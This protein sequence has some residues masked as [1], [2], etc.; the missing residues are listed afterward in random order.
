MI[1]SVLIVS[2]IPLTIVYF[3]LADLWPPSWLDITDTV[4]GVSIIA[5]GV[6]GICLLPIPGIWKATV[7]AGYALCAVWFQFLM[8]IFFRG[9]L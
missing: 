7:S 6:V 1:G 9:G 5:V 2:P 3:Q 4:A 8:A